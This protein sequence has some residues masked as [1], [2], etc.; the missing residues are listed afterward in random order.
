MVVVMLLV[1]VEMKRGWVNY[2]GFEVNA[3]EFRM[4]LALKS[5]FEDR[6]KERID[7]VS[8]EWMREVKRIFLAPSLMKGDDPL[9]LFLFAE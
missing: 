6:I 9:Y 2:G 4:N 3:R 1:V 8:L 7:D 5:P